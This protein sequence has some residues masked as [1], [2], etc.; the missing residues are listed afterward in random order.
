MIKRS[1]L[2]LFI[3]SYILTFLC[4]LF[5]FVMWIKH[6]CPI[7]PTEREIKS[8]KVEEIKK[9]TNAENKDAIDSLLNE[10]YLFESK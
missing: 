6:E 4:G 9:I 5:F 10:L 1:L 2:I 7:L 3:T 8:E